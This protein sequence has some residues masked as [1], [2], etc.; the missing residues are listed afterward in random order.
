M[1]KRVN[2]VTD[3]FSCMEYG[4]VDDCCRYGVYITPEEYHRLISDKKASSDDFS[5]PKLDGDGDMGYRTVIGRRGCVFLL[6]ERGCRFHGTRYKPFLC[7]IFPRDINEA[8]TAYFEGYLPCFNII[9]G[10]I[11]YDSRSLDKHSCTPG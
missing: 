1:L 6:P 9:K 8:E 4:C 5:G 2:S 10:G 7:Q 11:V 3:I